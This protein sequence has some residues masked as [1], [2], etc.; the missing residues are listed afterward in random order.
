MTAVLS[1]RPHKTDPEATRPGSGCWVNVSRCH[2]CGELAC[3][4]EMHLHIELTGNGFI[5]AC[6]EACAIKALAAHGI[7]SM[8]VTV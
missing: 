8:E 4:P 6:S 7:T 1:I 5:A 3:Q 2:G